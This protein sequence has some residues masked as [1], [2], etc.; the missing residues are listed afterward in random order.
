MIRNTALTRPVANNRKN[1]K[2]TKMHTRATEAWFKERRE[3]AEAVR[4]MLE[5]RKDLPVG[6]PDRLFTP[7]EWE[8]GQKY[9]NQC[10]A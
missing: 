7:K 2:A 3:T 1:R 9:L 4:Q 6:H 10:K 8:I 5:V